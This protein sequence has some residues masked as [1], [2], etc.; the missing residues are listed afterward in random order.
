MTLHEAARKYGVETHYVSKIAPGTDQYYHQLPRPD[1]DIAHDILDRLPM[2]TV[3]YELEHTSDKVSPYWLAKRWNDGK[4]EVL[5]DGTF[6]EAVL[7]LAERDKG[8]TM[9]RDDA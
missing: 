1:L 8:N 7:A 6:I 9:T 4:W 2:R 5:S 3:G